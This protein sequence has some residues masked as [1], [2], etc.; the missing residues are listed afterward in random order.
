MP[1]L[2]DKPGVMKSL[3]AFVNR[4]IVLVVMVPLIVSVHLGWLA[5]QENP[6]LVDQSTRRHHFQSV[7]NLFRFQLCDIL[8]P[9]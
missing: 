4:N 9:R 2:P 1:D 7:R 8:F 6:K 5:I 3:K